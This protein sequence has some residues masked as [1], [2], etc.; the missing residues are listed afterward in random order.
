MPIL[1]KSEEEYYEIPDKVLKKCKVS[2]EQFEKGRE[3]MAADVEGQCG[4]C[5]LVDLRPCDCNFKS[6]WASC[7]K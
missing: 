7:L 6:Y 5:S 2:K 4:D 1:I 3:K